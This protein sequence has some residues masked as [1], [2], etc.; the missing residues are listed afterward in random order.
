MHNIQM[1][2]ASRGYLSGQVQLANEDQDDTSTTNQSQV[3]LSTGC[4]IPSRCE[5]VEAGLGA[6]K[7]VK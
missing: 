3:H 1:L 5:L 4:V 7:I 2:E 6:K